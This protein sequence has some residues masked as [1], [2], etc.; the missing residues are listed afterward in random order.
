[1]KYTVEVFFPNIRATG[2]DDAFEVVRD[3]LQDHGL[4]QGRDW[5]AYTTCV[6]SETT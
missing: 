5:D 2:K 1:M 6:E 4:D 3:L